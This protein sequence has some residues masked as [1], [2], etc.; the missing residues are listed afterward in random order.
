M[1][2]KPSAEIN[3]TL[4]GYL[5]KLFYFPSVGV[6][7]MKS[8]TDEKSGLPAPHCFCPARVLNHSSAVKLFPRLFVR[9]GGS[10]GDDSGHSDCSPNEKVLSMELRVIGF[11]RKIECREDCR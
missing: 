5:G 11:C 4:I 10:G 6:V 1:R 9:P 7:N 3:S 8:H 2:D